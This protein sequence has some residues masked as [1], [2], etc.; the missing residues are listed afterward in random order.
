MPALVFDRQNLEL[1]FVAKYFAEVGVDGI[2]WRDGIKSGARI[3][4]GDVLA[5]LY[6]ADGITEALSA[7]TGCDGVIDAT[8][9]RIEFDTLGKRPS[10][11]ALR[12]T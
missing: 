1:R 3:A 5:D 4:Q 2:T 10:Q 6:W 8:N 12:L 7:P 9:R 11:W